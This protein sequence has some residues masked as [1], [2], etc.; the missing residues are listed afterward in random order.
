[1]P[2]PAPPV[3]IAILPS[4]LH[5]VAALPLSASCRPEMG[6]LEKHQPLSFRRAQRRGICF[7]V[8]E[9]QIPRFARNDS[10]GGFHLHWWAKGP[11]NTPADNHF[12]GG[13]WTRPR[14]SAGGKGFFRRKSAATCW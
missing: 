1:M 4:S 13:T 14:E 12:E 7:S 6:T 10:F 5:M 3:T 2:G 8:N 11:W 9:K